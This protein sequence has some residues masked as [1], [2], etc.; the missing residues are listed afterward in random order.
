MILSLDLDLGN[1][2]VRM[3]L[4][5]SGDDPGEGIQYRE[6]CAVWEAY[7]GLPMWPQQWGSLLRYSCKH[8][9]LRTTWTGRLYSG[10]QWCTVAYCTQPVVRV[11]DGPRSQLTPDSPAVRSVESLTVLLRDIDMRPT[12]K[13]NIQSVKIILIFIKMYYNFYLIISSLVLLLPLTQGEKYLHI[14]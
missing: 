4:I 8:P 7:K 10:V 3:T 5:I 6:D 2:F 11:R 1:I 9:V 14:L 12:N 13:W